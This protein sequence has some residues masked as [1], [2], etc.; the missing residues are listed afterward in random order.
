[1]QVPK[2]PTRYGAV[3]QSFHWIVAAFIVAQ[4]LL[5]PVPDVLPPGIHY[6]PPFGLDKLVLLARHKSFGMTVLMLMILRLLW[7]RRNPPP[8]LPPTMNAVERFLARATHIAFYAVLF[9]MPLSGWLM[10][11]AKG[12]SASWFGLFTWP[13]LVGMN[14]HVFNVTSATHEILSRVLFVLALLHVAAALKHHFWNKDGVLVRM[15][16]FTRSEK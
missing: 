13:N 16:P 3:A 8:D 7:R 14:E 2:S 1:M 12:S 9:A 10:T 6:N 11:S 15:L 5:I 4:Y